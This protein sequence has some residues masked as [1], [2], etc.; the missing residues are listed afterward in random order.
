MSE[1]DT[2]P[3]SRLEVPEGIDE[4]AFFTLPDGTPTLAGHA[5]LEATV[6]NEEKPHLQELE[7]YWVNKPFAFV[8]IY[9]HTAQQEYRYYL[10]EPSLS[11]TE[12]A[13]VDFFADKL[14]LSIDYET[15]AT[16][17]SPTDRAEVVRDETIRLMHR[18]NLLS[19]DLGGDR[20]GLG[21]RLKEWLISVLRRRAAKQARG[22]DTVDPVP[23]DRDSETGERQSLTD[24]Q[25]ETLVYYLVRNFI[26]Y[27]RIDGLK[28]DVNVEDISCDGY[29]EPV[30]V[31]HSNYGQLLT[32]VTFGEAELDEF[33]IELAQRARKGISKRQ[34]NVDATLEDGSRAQLTLGREVS[35]RGTNFTIRQFREV[36]FTP[37]D[38]VTWETYSLSQMVYLWLAIE[39][40]KSMVIAGGTASGKTTTLNALSLFIPS[41]TKLVS[42]EDTRELLMPQRNWVPTTTRESFQTDDGSA[43]DEFELLE[44]ALRKRPDYIIMGEVRGEEGRTLFQ[45]MNTGHTVC[46]TFHANSPK[47]VIRRFTEEPINVASSMFSAVDI[48][49]NQT[50][51]TVDGQRVRRATGLVEIDEYDAQA[52]EFVVD[53]TYDWDSVTDEIRATTTDTTDL[54][55]EVR[56]DN[57]WTPEQFQREWRERE[58][59]LAYLIREGIDTYAGVA[60]TIQAYTHSP[61]LTMSLVG[62]DELAARV[63]DLTTMRTID[64]D[65]DDEVEDLVPRPTPGADLRAEVESVLDEA[66]DLLDAYDTGETGAFQ[67]NTQETGGLRDIGDPGAAGSDTQGQDGSRGAGDSGAN[68]G[69][70]RETGGF[71]DAWERLDTE[72]AEGGRHDSGGDTNGATSRA[73]ASRNRDRQQPRDGT[74]HSEEGGVSSAETGEAS[75]SVTRVPSPEPPTDRGDEG[76]GDR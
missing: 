34:P 20:E 54:M 35:D 63:D 76:G 36:P 55:E 2:L 37:V 33:V 75:D 16:D 62:R 58:A 44:D 5:D 68:R 15:V 1:T 71:P 12:R 19:D 10:V 57:G 9:R 50:S 70:P 17:A 43:I 39:S 60:A 64:I 73:G 21:G 41:D 31:Y 8:V 22:D 56:L 61:E 59:L 53:R 51:T 23:V 52:E 32:N 24:D 46:T 67:G 28:H 26:R 42:I 6:P 18:Y 72:A 11:D 13:L 66:T 74:A 45:A 48:V 65:V 4:R 3:Q 14:K 49:A 27:D 30:F 38:L 69:V 7:R 40:G 25:V 47:E 29:N